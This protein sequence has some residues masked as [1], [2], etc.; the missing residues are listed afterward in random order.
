MTNNFVCQYV[1]FWKAKAVNLVMNSI[2]CSG[3]ELESFQLQLFLVF[4][5]CNHSES[6]ASQSIPF[7][8]KH[9]FLK[10]HILSL[11]TLGET[12]YFT[13]LNIMN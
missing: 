12:F 5:F 6:A 4:Y 2:C 8:R 9:V 1:L 11:G 10:I 13:L 3:K 7:K